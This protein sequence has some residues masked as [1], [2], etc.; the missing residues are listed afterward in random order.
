MRNPGLDLL[1]L[2][3]VL[4]V[5]GNHLV[6]P[7]ADVDLPVAGFLLL[8]LWNGG[9]WIGVDLFFVLSGFLVSGLLFDE[10]LRTGNVR[11]K[12]FLWRRAWKIYPAFWVM[13][14]FTIAY[15]AFR[16]SEQTAIGIWGELL[17]LQNY[18]G[19]VGN[20]TWS[21]AVEEHFYIGLVLLVALLCWRNKA[22]FH[23]I[24][25]VFVVVAVGCLAFRLQ[26]QHLNPTYSF[27]PSLTPTH[28]RVDALMF[29]V[30]LSY[31]VRYRGL[32]EKLQSIR[33]P[34]LVALGACLV[35][36][37]FVF[38][39]PDSPHLLTY[40]LIQIYVGAGV[41]VLAAT[42]LKSVNARVLKLGA[43]LGT[44]S[45]S[46]YLWHMLVDSTT[47]EL[48][49]MISRTAGYCVYAS[50]YV[51]GT[52]AFGYFMAKIIELP[53]LR[54]REK[55]MPTQPAL[56]IPTV[57][58]IELPAPAVPVTLN[59]AQPPTTDSNPPIGNSNPPLGDSNPPLVIK[60]ATAAARPAA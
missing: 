49:R 29:G 46:I 38:R 58:V 21:L 14:L 24:P 6:L 5:V 31:L 39:R 8:K 13:I 57:R 52:F 27:Y 20:H 45:Y 34:F 3:A 11:L 4:L 55:L 9:G 48:G 40:G 2:V 16:G 7:W 59:S 32:L 60:T 36:P 50:L 44:A 19:H 18:L 23:L 37:A 10:H 25:A 33:T 15:N 47:V 54:L 26:H 1:R 56:A 30:L 53:V 43:T 42:R 22:R 41:L 28:F 35:F 12:R 51:G 17:F